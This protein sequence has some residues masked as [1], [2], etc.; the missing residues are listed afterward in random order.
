MQQ[1]IKEKLTQ[2]QIDMYIKFQIFQGLIL[3]N[4]L[5]Y[6]LFPDRITYTS[7]RC[8][9]SLTITISL[10]GISLLIYFNKSSFQRINSLYL[11]SYLKN[12]QRENIDKLKYTPGCEE[13]RIIG[14]KYTEVH[15][16]KLIK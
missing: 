15:D 12:L 11:I 2:F 16:T 8:L 10:I 14:L 4:I 3:N 9:V 5:K 7:N 6:I 1:H 13:I